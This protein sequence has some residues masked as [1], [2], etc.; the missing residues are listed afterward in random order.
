MKEMSTTLQE[1]SEIRELRK[2]TDFFVFFQLRNYLTFSRCESVV[3]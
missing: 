1:L 3:V 2:E